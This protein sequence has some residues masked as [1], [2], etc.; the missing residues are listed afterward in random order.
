MPLHVGTAA[1][2]AFV[3]C[4]Q[5]SALKYQLSKPDPRPPRMYVAEGCDGS[6]AMMQHAGLLLKMH[7]INT[8]EYNE[9]KELLDCVRNPYCD[10]TSGDIVEGIAQL[11][12][13]KRERGQT[14]MFKSILHRDMKATTSKRLV[15]MGTLAVYAARRNLLDQLVCMVRDCFLSTNAT[16]T[17]YGYPVDEVGKPTQLCFERR[18]STDQKDK[19]LIKVV[20]PWGHHNR[21]FLKESLEFFEK[22]EASGMKSLQ[23]AGYQAAKLYYEDLVAFEQGDVK[24]SVQAW[25]TL[26]DSWGVKAKSDKMWKYFDKLAQGAEYKQEPHA[27]T[28][29]NTQE[30]RDELRNLGKDYLFRAVQ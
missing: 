23:K 8:G 19:A 22:Q 7:G 3:F 5:A 28:I 2:G 17:H 15:G 25:T 10:T 27:D 1:F 12:R 9:Q 6:T 26:L 20:V 24:T 18:N 4:I 14:L 21:S 11:N 16:T 30:V 13:V 29:F